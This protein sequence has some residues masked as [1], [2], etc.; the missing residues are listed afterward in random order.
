MIIAVDPGEKNIGI[1]MFTYNE[2]KKMADLKVLKVVD[3]DTLW[4]NLAIAEDLLKEGHNH[5]F[6]IENFRV[7][8][9][10]RQSKNANM[11]QW[12]EVQ[13]VRVIGALEYAA[14]RMNNSKVVF[15]EPRI[16]GMAKK[17]CDIPGAKKS[18]MPDEVSA[19]CHGAHYMI[20][21]GMIGSV[22]QITKFG[23]ESL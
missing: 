9:N 2:E 21:Q 18:H 6:V 16:L 22:D 7:D 20:Q 11:F 5:T 12:S 1:A 19:Y 23:Q 15:Q 17:W 14:F 3:R 10:I 8:T 13:T 4:V